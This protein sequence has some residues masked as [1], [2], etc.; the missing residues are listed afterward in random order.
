MHENTSS[1]KMALPFYQKVLAIYEESEHETKQ[2]IDTC[3]ALND[4][5]CALED[6]GRISEARTHYERAYEQSYQHLG[7]RHTETAAFASNLALV[8]MDSFD[9]EVFSAV[10][11]LRLSLKTSEFINGV[12]NVEANECRQRL[13]DCL[14][15]C[16]RLS[17]TFSERKFQKGDQVQLSKDRAKVKKQ[18]HK[19]GGWSDDMQVFLGSIGAVEKIDSDGDIHVK[20]EKQARSLG[21]DFSGRDTFCWNPESLSLMRRPESSPGSTRSIEVPELG[22]IV[23]SSGQGGL[24]KVFAAE[25][26]EGKEEQAAEKAV[27]Q[28]AE[29]LLLRAMSGLEKDV[30]EAKQAR[31]AANILMKHYETTGRK[32]DLKAMQK[33]ADTIEAWCSSSDESGS[34]EE[35]DDY[36]EDDSDEEGFREVQDVLLERNPEFA[37]ALQDHS[38]EHVSIQ[39]LND[40]M[41]QL[42]VINKEQPPQTARAMKDRADTEKALKKRIAIVQRRDDAASLLDGGW[43]A[44]VEEGTPPPS[45]R[46]KKKNDTVAQDDGALTWTTSARPVATPPPRAKSAAETLKDQLTGLKLGALRRRVG[47]MGATEEELDDLQDEDDPKAALIRWAL[48]EHSKSAGGDDEFTHGGLTN[49]ISVRNVAATGGAA[50][51]VTPIRMKAP[52]T[53]FSEA[54]EGVPPEPQITQTQHNLDALSLAVAGGTPSPSHGFGRAATTG[55][56][57]GASPGS[58]AA[59][60]AAFDVLLAQLGL[61]AFA[62]ALRADAIPNADELRDATEG[63]LVGLGVGE[64][65]RVRV[66]AWR[67][68][69]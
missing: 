44:L 54:Q 14:F 51:P 68:A 20:F 30:E 34:E 37:D 2:Y 11:L 65:E 49:I 53:G 45:A 32:K 23:R 28:E 7:A 10:P 63:E 55:F 4:V 15:Q 43:N 41:N 52:T 16:Y 50:G 6:M 57:G 48:K 33:R 59:E 42:R 9:E 29:A 18:A 5:A 61:S 1:P 69:A 58:A 26:L 46:N 47:E 17:K 66:A 39:Q 19:H 12:E 36:S 60:D 22:T 8:I 40:V 31:V 13:G 38:D 3:S 35:S 25:G 21:V 67:K 56:V 24:G 62:G 64:E 27:L